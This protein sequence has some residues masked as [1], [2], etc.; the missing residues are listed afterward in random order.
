MH[1]YILHIF[2]YIYIYMLHIFG[3]YINPSLYRFVI[4]S[5]FVSCL[6]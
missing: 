5:L 1:V 2:C 4:L 3:Y 6:S